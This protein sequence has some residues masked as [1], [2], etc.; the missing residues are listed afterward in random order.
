[1]TTSSKH[2]YFLGIG[3]IGMSALA[4]YYQHQGYQI[5]GYDLTATPL[6]RQLEL[7]GMSIHYIEDVNKIPDNPEMVVYT[8]AIPAGNK[9]LIFCGT[10]NFPLIKRAALLG[11]ISE[12][13][14]TVAVAGTHGKTSISALVAHLL[15][16]AGKMISAFVGGITKNY[17]SNLILSESTD[18][19]VVEADEFDRSFLMLK[20][21]IAI[22][23]SMDADHLDIYENHESL[24]QAFIDFSH[25]INP[26]GL[27]IHHSK[28]SEAFTGT[29]NK[30]SYGIDPNADLKA[31]NIQVNNHRFEFDIAYQ[32]LNIKNI[33][34]QVPGIHYIE[35]ALA[36]VGVALQLGLS[37]E[38]IKSGLMSFS[39]VERRFDIRINNKKVVYIDDYAHHPEEIRATV[40]AV[41]MLYP[42]KKI[43]GIFQ[44]HLFSR[45]RDFAPEFAKSLLPL[46][47][48]ALLNIYPARETPIEGITS[49]TILNLI[50]HQ[51][52]Y[53]IEKED[54]LPF[55]Q[56]QTFEV[57][58]TMGAGDIGQMVP[59][60]EQKL[61]IC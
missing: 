11:K 34:L 3:G 51:N 61:A 55:I 19:F 48:V 42:N 30:L 36:A 31:V 54:L 45:T 59:L 27:L 32:N 26:S 49:S 52:K 4:R 9:E 53:V 20:P 21:N 58:L 22:I 13:Y 33:T 16:N 46:D 2:I 35:N 50:E 43:L 24:N 38:E 40:E 10:R 1:M 7:A 39:G 57:L 37:S 60:I 15:K 18:V 44:P 25:Q 14:Y 23:S 47:V 41:K 28:L 56:E 29:S 17:Q 5:S 12:Q 8:P 6:T